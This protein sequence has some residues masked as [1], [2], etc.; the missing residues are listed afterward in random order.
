MIERNP[1]SRTLRQASNSEDL[2]IGT[3]IQ[4]NSL[5]YGTIKGIITSNPIYMSG[6]WAYFIDSSPNNDFQNPIYWVPHE[7]Y[8]LTHAID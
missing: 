1:I 3:L 7:M 8:G 5:A 2:Q 6:L 4:W